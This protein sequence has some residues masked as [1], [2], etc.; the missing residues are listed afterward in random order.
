MSIVAMLPSRKHPEVSKTTLDRS[1]GAVI[2]QTPPLRIGFWGTHGLFS[3]QV[4]RSLLKHNALV[5]VVLPASAPG[6]AVVLRH[7]PVV[8]AVADEL[9]LVN[10][11][12]APDTIQIAWQ[13]HIPAYAVQRLRSAAVEQW[14]TDQAVD[15][16]CVACFPW[17]IPAPLLTLPTYGFLNLHPSLLP[18]YRGP[19]P[20]FW[21]L[22]DGRQTIGVTAHWMDAELDTGAVAAQQTLHL[23]EGA[24]SAELDRLCAATGAD[25]LR[26]VLQQLEQGVLLQQPQPAGGS[27]HP[28]PTAADFRLSSQWSAR[29]AY[30]FMCGTDEWQ[31]PYPLVIAGQELL[32]RRALAYVPAQQLDCP[33]V[34]NG[35]EVLVQLTPGVLRALLW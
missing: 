16:V 14:L 32:L 5:H 6:A 3:Q 25:L 1:I 11:Y 27:Q 34:Y 23:P 2:A 20:L 9:L 18:A 29:H 19:A 28:W 21:Q 7:P 31:Q 24:S 22:R 30:T 13:Q 33:L 8:A 35:R 12:V 4:L 15:V 10:Q 17:R 26:Q